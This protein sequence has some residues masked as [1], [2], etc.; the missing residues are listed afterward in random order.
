MNIRIIT[1]GGTIDKEYVNPDDNY[2]VGSPS[3]AAILDEAFVS[4]DYQINA[5][6]KK[7]SLELTDADRDCI[8]RAV[9]SSPEDLIIITH[10]TDTMT[11]TADRLAGGVSGKT[12]VLTGALAPAKFRV[13][14]ATFNI[15]LAVG[16]VQSLPA[17]V[18]IAMNGRVFKA[19][20]V[21]K[22]RAAGR[23]EDRAE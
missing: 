4:F 10:G 5:L 16:A 3:I 15:G 7:D 12:V 13:S 9:Q 1:C 17:G 23:F 22:N 20:K 18:Y 2:K 11:Q 21:I 8:L 6:L 19:G 14:D